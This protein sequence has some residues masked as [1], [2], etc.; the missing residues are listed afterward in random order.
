MVIMF[1]GALH[2]ALAYCVH[3]NTELFTVLT[4]CLLLL[5]LYT[6]HHR[7]AL[8][9]LVLF[10]PVRQFFSSLIDGC[11]KY[12]NKEEPKTGPHRARAEMQ[13][14]RVNYPFNVYLLFVII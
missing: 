4:A 1:A 13:G 2:Q 5:L 6:K 12:Q 3:L 8:D 10:P 11:L 7:A 14:S 9:S